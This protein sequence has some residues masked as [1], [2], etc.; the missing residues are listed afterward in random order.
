MGQ[1]SRLPCLSFND[2]GWAK[3]KLLA[4]AWPLR[5]KRLA[6]CDSV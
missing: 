3:V 5:S 6:L 1:R 4:K 2:T